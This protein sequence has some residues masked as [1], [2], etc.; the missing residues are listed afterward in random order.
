MKNIVEFDITNNG[1]IIVTHNGKAINDIN[2]PVLVECILGRNS[3]V[4]N[5]DDFTVN[6]ITMYGSKDLNKLSKIDNSTWILEYE[7][8]V[9]SWI[10]KMLNYG[11]LIKEDN[12]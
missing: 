1:N 12:E 11:W 9:F 8:P 4:I 3:L 7:Y 2:G 6:S 5:G 10:H